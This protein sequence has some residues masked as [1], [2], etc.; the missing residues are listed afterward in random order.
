MCLHAIVKCTRAR[1]LAI[2]I[3][4]MVLLVIA[5][6]LE[7][8]SLAQ[9][10]LFLIGASTLG[11]T[12]YLEKQRMLIALQLIITLGAIL[13]FFP[14]V[15]PYLKYAVLIGALVAALAYLVKIGYFRSDAWG[16]IGA[17]GLACI[18]AA[19]STDA[20]AYR[21]AFYSLLSAGGLII[22]LYSGIWFFHK[23]LR[24]AAIWLILNLLLSIYPLM[25][26]FSILE[27]W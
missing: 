19:L 14:A 20:V 21:L 2:G 18:A 22:A 15:A 6:L 24:I 8:G 16:W 9:K 17:L 26:V 7:A 10:I 25:V 3:A 5:T 12:A 4:A 1:S 23:K 13:A 11:F 27:A